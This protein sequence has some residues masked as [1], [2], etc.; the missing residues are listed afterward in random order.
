MPDVPKYP[1]Y[2]A[3]R[4]EL[5]PGKEN[6]NLEY[7]QRAQLRDAMAVPEAEFKAAKEIWQRY[8]TMVG[9]TNA[10]FSVARNPN[11][12][13]TATH[14][15]TR[16]M[17]KREFEQ[18]NR[19]RGWG[20]SGSP[21]AQDKWEVMVPQGD[22]SPALLAA[23]YMMFTEHGSDASHLMKYVDNE[24]LPVFYASLESARVAVMAGQWYHRDDEVR[25]ALGNQMR[26]LINQHGYSSDV[27]APFMAVRAQAWSVS[28]WE[29]TSPEQSDAAIFAQGFASEIERAVHYADDSI[30]LDVAT[31]LAAQYEVLFT[32]TPVID[33]PM[34]PSDDTGDSSG[35]GEDGNGGGGA[36]DGDED[37]PSEEEE[38]EV[39]EASEG[40]E[41]SA[42]D[43]G[44]ES[45]SQW[46]Q[47]LQPPSTA[48][49]MQPL[50]PSLIDVQANI[51]KDLRAAK[52]KAKGQVT[53]VQNKLK[54]VEDNIGTVQ[55]SY[56]G[57][58]LLNIYPAP[59]QEKIES[60]AISLD[61][62]Q[63]RGIVNHTRKYVG[64]PSQKTWE[65]SFGNTKVFTRGANTRGRVG[66]LID[67]SG[68]M[69][70]GCNACTH[71]SPSSPDSAAALAY[72]AAKVIAELDNDAIVAAY[73]GFDEIYRLKPGHALT[74]GAY[75]Q[76]GGATPT[77]AA[78]EWLEK[79]MG[80]ELEGAACVLIT[81]G[82]PSACGA[83]NGPTEH[84]SE[85]AH[86]MYNAGMRFGCVVVRA[87]Q[88]VAK[89][90]P[91]PVTVVVNKRSELGNIQ[92]IIDS[93]GGNL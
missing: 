35:E 62:Q 50:P 14:E 72:A 65:L 6:W 60:E 85:I 10:T 15:S 13:V 1:D 29:V 55:V 12:E 2:D 9:N 38:R 92:N 64:E 46:T 69:G 24:S 47:P 51:A 25:N 31:Q 56:A 68:S 40:D 75:K 52:G 87:N 80:G 74:H 36:Y 91:Q 4:N 59:A 32:S 20:D 21:I 89:H 67:I 19:Y 28:P 82:H 58:H 17:T 49:V 93:I 53:R 81:D 16:V 66:I 27:L 48:P 7:D 18:Q 42:D 63:S 54:G 90:L 83:N 39:V 79:S 88:S 33:D 26:N 11:A 8:Y 86:R 30:V 78:L 37:E 61:I 5:F 22:E 43:D 41:D 23:S 84:T 73:C 44:Q 3:K 45:P 76:T 70:C 77:C 71:A 57:D 34:A